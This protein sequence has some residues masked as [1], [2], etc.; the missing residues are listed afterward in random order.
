[1]ARSTLRRFF[2]YVHPYRGS[3]VVALLLG[4]VRSNMPL[5]FPWAMGRAVDEFIPH[6]GVAPSL[7]GISLGVFFAGILIA[8]ALLYPVL[9][10]RVWIMGR[11]AHRVIFDLRYDLY[12]H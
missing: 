10:Y 11:A 7:G 12:Q 1:M 8:F 4:V 9:Y 3:I 5:L 2:D 6:G